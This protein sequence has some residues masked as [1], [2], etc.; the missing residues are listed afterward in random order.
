MG[1][2]LTRLTLVH[3]AEVH[4]G[5]R[6]FVRWALDQVRT[7]VPVDVGGCSDGF[8]SLAPVLTEAV[9]THVGESRWTM[10]PAR[11]SLDRITRMIEECPKITQCSDAKCDRCRDAIAG[12]PMA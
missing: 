2:D 5:R 4:A 1:V 6:P 10:L 7:V 9:V 11:D 3:L 8:G 12:G